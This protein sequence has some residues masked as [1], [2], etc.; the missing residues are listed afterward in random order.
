MVDRKVVWLVLKT[1]A[2]SAVSWVGQKA[3]CLVLTMV[4]N[5]DVSLAALTVL[6]LVV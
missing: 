1:V 6:N 3:A 4:V 2:K 5:S